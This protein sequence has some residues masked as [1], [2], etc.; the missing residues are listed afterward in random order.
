[1]TKIR[2]DDNR[3]NYFCFGYELK[4]RTSRD[5]TI[6]AMTVGEDMSPNLMHPHWFVCVTYEFN[7]IAQA[8][9]CHFRDDLE[10]W[11]ALSPRYPRIGI[12]HGSGNPIDLIGYYNFGCD[13]SGRL[14]RITEDDIR[15]F[16]QIAADYLKYL[17]SYGMF[18]FEVSQFLDR[19]KMD[20]DC[21]RPALTHVGIRWCWEDVSC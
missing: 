21:K 11:E 2:I 17:I 3:H 13:Q 19:I 9:H 14:N 18:S 4:T 12:C 7:L 6:C 1:M 10:A 15:V 20:A 8:I 5:Q 16:N